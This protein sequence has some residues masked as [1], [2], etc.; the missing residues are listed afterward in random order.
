VHITSSQD[1]EIRRVYPKY[2][3]WKKALVKLCQEQ[4]FRTW[5]IFFDEW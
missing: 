5:L 4:F 2:T 1:D 3:I